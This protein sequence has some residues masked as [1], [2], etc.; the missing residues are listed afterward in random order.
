MVAGL[1]D[2]NFHEHAGVEAQTASR[3]Q[4]R[5]SEGVLQPDTVSLMRTLGLPLR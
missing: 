5:F 1:G 4:R 3:W 2:M